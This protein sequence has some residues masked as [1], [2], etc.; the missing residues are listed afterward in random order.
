MEV[1]LKKSQYVFTPSSPNNGTIEI[2][3]VSISLELQNF[4][5]IINVTDDRRSLVYDDTKIKFGARWDGVDTLTLQTNTTGMK[6][7]DDL[8]IRILLTEEQVID[9]F[10]GGGG[11]SVIGSNS[12]GIFEFL[13]D[14]G[15]INATGNYSGGAAT[16]FLYT[17]TDAVLVDYIT[18][19]TVLVSDNGALRA[20][21]YGSNLILSNG[22]II[23]K[24]DSGGVQD[25]IITN[26]N[27][28]KN[29]DYSQNVGFTP[30]TDYGAGTNFLT[31]TW[32]FES[33]GGF[34]ELNEN[35]SI[36]V[37]LND[38]FSGLVDHTFLIKGFRK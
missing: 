4:V 7:D 27:I 10:N 32:N 35:E 2:V 28:L 37:D 23:S 18:E 22:V 12:L 16:Q 6:F 5:Q 34:I 25:L 33:Y 14:G 13:K 8:Q 21:R 24:Y 26:N 30:R 9:L 15:N 29:A 17:N 3:G 1:I 31:A 20:D 36:R 11:S 19:L 38:N